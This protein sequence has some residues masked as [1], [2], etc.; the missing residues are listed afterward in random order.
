MTTQTDSAGGDIHFFEFHGTAREYFGIWIVN[1]LL[2]IL[3]L[4]IYSAWAKVRTKRYFYRATTLDNANFDYHGRPVAILKGR[5]TAVAL[6]V[7]YQFSVEFLPPLAIALFIVFIVGLPWLVNRALAFN[8]YNSS[9][10]NLRFKF[11]ARYRE[12]FFAFV[13]LGALV[14]L[15]FGLLYPFW[16]HRRRKFIVEHSGYGTQTFA[17]RALVSSFYKV[18]L[19]AG[20]MMIFGAGIA[21][22]LFA[23]RVNLSTPLGFENIVAA[24]VLLF[25]FPF[26][27]MIYAYIGT[28][29]TNLTFNHADL[30][31]H[32]LRSTLRARDV[33]WLYFSNLVA[34]ALSLGLLIPWAQ[35]RLA[36]YRAQHL[37]LLPAGSLGSFIASTQSEVAATGEEMADAFDIDLGL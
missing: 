15:S 8:A 3:T 29:L 20:L 4:G 12:A 21:L 24:I 25:V 28:R 1:T 35:I 27:L 10:R 14:P 30:A 13:A 23:A 32:R 6:L 37:R 19:A 16:Q 34:I 33:A 11:S 5:L 2:T 36:R 26:Y 7:L 9:Y 22:A 17:M 31:G 18:Y